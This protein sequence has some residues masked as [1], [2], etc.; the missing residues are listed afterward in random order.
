MTDKTDKS[1]AADSEDT[2]VDRAPADRVANA[3][4]RNLKYTHTV[5]ETEGEMSDEVASRYYKNPD[6]VASLYCVGCGAGIR[7]G[8]DGEMVW[9]GTKE[10]VPGGIA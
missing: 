3:P 9:S 4:K 1:T 2:Q 10:K 7:I 8:D 5:C 6:E